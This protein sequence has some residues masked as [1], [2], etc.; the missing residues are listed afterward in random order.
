M[1]L[2]A[3][4]QFARPSWKS[5]FKM[6]SLKNSQAKF[7]LVMDSSFSERAFPLSVFDIFGNNQ[8]S[9]SGEIFIQKQLKRRKSW[10]DAKQNW[11][12][13]SLIAIGLSKLIYGK[14]SVKQVPRFRFYMH[15]IRSNWLLIGYLFREYYPYESHSDHAYIVLHSREDFQNLMSC[16]DNAGKLKFRLYFGIIYAA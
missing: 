6:S 4:V 3:S 8:S 16:A 11:L 2:G 10:N 12:Q 7:P 5:A 15:F 1:V 9:V 13:Q 14:K